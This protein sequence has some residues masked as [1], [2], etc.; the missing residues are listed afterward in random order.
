MKWART[1]QGHRTPP[2]CAFYITHL[3]ILLPQ[4]KNWWSQMALIHHV[5]LLFWEPWTCNT[6]KE[7]KLIS[8]HCKLKRW[9]GNPFHPHCPYPSTLF[10]TCFTARNSFGFV[11]CNTDTTC[12][13]PIMTKLSSSLNTQCRPLFGNNIMPTDQSN[14]YLNCSPVVNLK[15]LNFAFDGSELPAFTEEK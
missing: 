6:R 11:H 12:S 2:K 3:I 7:K 15:L 9:T 14:T 1:N 5:P 8:L 13:M 10:C 4:L